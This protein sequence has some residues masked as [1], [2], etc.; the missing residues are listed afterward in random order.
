[1]RKIIVVATL[2]FFT[3]SCKTTHN[4]QAD[5]SS[6]PK[7]KVPTLKSEKTSVLVSKIKANQFNYKWITAHFSIDVDKDSLNQSFS[8]D[9]RMKKDSV[10]WM[11]VRAVLGT[12][13]AARIMVTED[14]AMIM[15]RIDDNYFL[16][17]YNYINTRLN[18]G[19]DVD[20]DLLH[21]VMTGSSMEFYSD[22]SKMNSYF[23]GKQYIISTIRKRNLRRVLYKNRPYHSKENAQ[24]IFLDPN[25]FHITHVRLEDFV[26]HRTFDAYYSDFQKV[27]SVMFP[28]HIQYQIA[29]QK[30]IKIDLQYKKVSFK[31]EET[32]PF[33]VPKK[34]QRVQ[35]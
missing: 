28:F 20:F 35:Y 8:G 29:A 17:D 34:Y 19:D 10:I 2:L 1:M 4:I 18:T 5:N 23:D 24:F 30:N 13:E 6:Q 14:S 25:D 31:Q 11:S 16:G 33:I 9:L 7:N 15:N 21:S 12:I 22:T 3:I 27:D 32:V 26:N